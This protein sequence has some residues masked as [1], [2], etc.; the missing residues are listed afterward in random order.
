MPRGDRITDIYNSVSL[1][2]LIPIGGENVAGFHGSP[3]LSVAAGTEPF[4]TIAN[5]ESVTEYP[6]PGEVVWRDTRGVTC[7]RWNWRQC[8]RTQLSG[9]ATCVLFTLDALSCM[10][11]ETV[12]AAHRA[13]VDRLTE[14]AP[15]DNVYMRMLSA[16]ESIAPPAHTS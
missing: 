3:R 4:E 10:T 16:S 14:N 2:F 5:G 11:D 8:R 13:L 6:E 15:A 1:D 7:R 12:D 9:S